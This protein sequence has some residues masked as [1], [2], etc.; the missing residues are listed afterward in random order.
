MNTAEIKIKKGYGLI[1]REA[2]PNVLFYPWP[3]RGK[4]LIV[5]VSP[6]Y[7]K[8]N[9][10]V[11]KCKLKKYLFENKTKESGTNFATR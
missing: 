7:R 11:R 10:K 8:G 6:N 5:L 4:G 1:A 3:F 9:N 2:N